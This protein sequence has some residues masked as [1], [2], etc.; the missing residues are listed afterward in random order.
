V[1]V[2]STTTKQ[3]QI[4]AYLQR[5]SKI[6]TQTKGAKVSINQLELEVKAPHGLS[7]D[8][9]QSVCL[10]V[11]RTRIKEQ[12]RAAFLFGFMVDGSETSCTVANRL[13][14]QYLQDREG[15]FL[16]YLSSGFPP[17]PKVV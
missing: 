14:N 11:A 13:P 17:G 16:N 1:K 6:A 5:P 12:K 10:F 9:T 4:K 15:D 7:P 8:S 2:A 3:M